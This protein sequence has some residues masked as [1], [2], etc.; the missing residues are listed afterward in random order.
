[1]TYTY[2]ILP[3]ICII[4]QDGLTNVVENI[5]WRYTGVDT[6]GNSFTLAGAT[7]VPSPNPESFT[8]FASLTRE[9]ILGWL[10]TMQDQTA[11]QAIIVDQINKAKNPV[12]VTLSLP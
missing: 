3:L 11:A 4:S 2:E 6:K 5:P 8:P 1:M 7:K 10:D 9:I 12:T